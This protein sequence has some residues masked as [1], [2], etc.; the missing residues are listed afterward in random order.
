[1]RSAAWVLT[2]TS[3]VAF[4]YVLGSTQVFPLA[5]AQPDDVSVSEES[6]KKIVEA[7]DAL[8]KAMEQLKLESRYE[9]VTKGVNSYAVLVGGINAKEDLESGQ[10]VDPETFAALS[11]AAYQLKKYSIKDDSL[12]DWVDTNLLGYDNNG[13]LTYRNKVVRIYSISRLR[14]LDAQRMVILGET[15]DNKKAR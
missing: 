8:K 2:A 6:T 11:T 13:H 3:L 12:A 10:G 15:T 4:G 5:H 7:H 14:R 1:M 9:S